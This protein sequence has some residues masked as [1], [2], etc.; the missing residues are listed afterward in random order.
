MNDLDALK[1]LKMLIKLEED[2]VAFGLNWADQ[3][4]IL[5]QIQNECQEI[6]EALIQRENPERVQEEIG[7]LLQAVISLCIFSEFKLDEILL[8]VCQKFSLRLNNIKK[9]SKLY[10]LDTLHGLSNEEMM[11]L[12]QEAK[13]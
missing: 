8:K 9:V 7:D 6:R 10:G 1:S 2:A 3:N 12:W 11:N 13:Q 4:M 5:D